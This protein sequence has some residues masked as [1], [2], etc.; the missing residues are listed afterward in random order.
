[1]T[2]SINQSALEA[3]TS[4]PVKEML[5][6]A[7][8]TDVAMA[9]AADMFELGV[10]VQ[11]LKRGTMFAIRANTLY[12]VFVE[13]SGL[14]SIPAGVAKQDGR[15]QCVDERFVSRGAAPSHCGPD[16]P[17]PAGGSDGC[18][19]RPATAQLRSASA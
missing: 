11:V 1:M 8:L 13:N 10:K 9:P 14:D 3:G 5:A 12:Q 6:Q 4:D 15:L 7:Q 16:R 2:G 19:A 17:Q 18:D